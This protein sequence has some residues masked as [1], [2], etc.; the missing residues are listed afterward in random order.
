MYAYLHRACGAPAFLMTDKPVPG[1]RFL[2]S[3]LFDLS[4]EQ[5]P[6]GSGHTCQSCGESMFGLG[7]NAENVVNFIVW[8]QQNSKK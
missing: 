8:K 4:Y 1:Q 7:G 5:L 2:S 6:P 3:P